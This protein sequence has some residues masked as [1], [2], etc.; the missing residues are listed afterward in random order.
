MLTGGEQADGIQPLGR[1]D[2]S[3]KDYSW[4]FS[5]D[6]FRESTCL[7]PGGF[8]EVVAGGFPLDEDLP[9]R[10]ATSGVEIPIK[11]WGLE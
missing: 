2:S 9:V 8:V 6:G 11:R 7:R 5:R 3:S 10:L 1:A 4:H